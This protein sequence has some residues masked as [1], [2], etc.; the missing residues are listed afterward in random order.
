VKGLIT[1]RILPVLAVVALLAGAAALAQFGHSV[2]LA[3]GSSVPLPRAVPVSTVTRACPAPGLAGMP[4]AGLALMAGTS[5]SGTGHAQVSHLGGAPLQSLSSPGLS[6]SRVK[7]VSAHPKAASP[8]PSGQ[9][10]TTV[11]AAGGVVVSASGALARGLEAEQVTAG[12]TEP[13]RCVSPGTDFWFTGPGRYSAGRIQLYLMNTASQAADVNVEAFT[14]AGPLQGSGDTGIAVAPGQMVVQS[15]GTLLRGSRVIALHVRTSVGQ[16]AAAVTEI[17]G[18]AR[19]GAWLPPAQEPATTVVLPGLPGAA[20]TRQLYVAVPGTR[21]AHIVLTAITGKGSYEPTGG[22]GLD[23]PG[24]AAVA[25]SLP[26]LSAI[27]AALKVSSNVPVTASL[28]LPGGQQGMPGVFTAAAPPIAEQGVAADGGAGPGKTAELVL[29]APWRAVRARIVPVGGGGP[30]AATAGG[31]V[32]Q[33]AAHHTVVEKLTPPPGTRRG[34]PF[35]VVVI[36]LP[37]SGLLYGARVL[38]DGGQGG[39]LR[40]I[41]PVASALTTVPLPPVRDELITGVP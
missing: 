29:S 26:S 11:P 2:T 15:L 28:M 12:G 16:V 33:I 17:T 19:V 9:P 25:I 40:S 4:D 21:N 18:T 32:V 1:S 14:D 8:T 10:V 20:G 24:G 5:A 37:G 27:P 34:S 38:T 39:T 23:I 35:A 31:S 7:T 41:L 6:V 30:G 3:A 36:P 22:G 13:L